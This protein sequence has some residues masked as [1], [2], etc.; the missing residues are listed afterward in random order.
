MLDW[1]TITIELVGIVILLM[2]I[3][4]PIQEFRGIFRIVTRKHRAA[5]AASADPAAP[6]PRQEGPLQ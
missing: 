1:I 4:I 6:P 5:D 2:W 3:V